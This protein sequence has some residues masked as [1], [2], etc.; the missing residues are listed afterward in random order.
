LG[1]IHYLKLGLDYQLNIVA[2]D[3]CVPHHPT[4]LRYVE[5]AGV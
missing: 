4:S 5:A 1:S 2:A 3:I